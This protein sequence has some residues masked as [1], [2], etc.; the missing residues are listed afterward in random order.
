MLRVK[1]GDLRCDICISKRS[2]VFD[3]GLDSEY[4]SN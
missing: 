3:E 2:V 1:E 4:L